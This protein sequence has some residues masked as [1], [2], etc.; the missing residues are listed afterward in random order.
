LHT[1][2]FNSQLNF[3]FNTEY[4]PVLEVVHLEPAGRIG[5]L[6]QPMSPHG[7][8]TLRRFNTHI[9]THTYM[10]THIV[11]ASNACVLFPTL[12]AMVELCHNAALGPAIQAP[13][14]DRQ[15]REHLQAW[16]RQK[17]GHV[18]NGVANSVE[19]RWK[20]S[21][22]FGRARDEMQDDSL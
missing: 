2:S 21:S 17:F 20:W 7:Y 1:F 13:G 18:G 5:P 9:G 19:L 8:I 3:N 4:L 12:V 15:L 16:W 10:H 11:N 6:Q 14:G 22:E